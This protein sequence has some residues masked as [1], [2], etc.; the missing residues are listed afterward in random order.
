[1]KD[2]LH[3]KHRYLYLIVLE[4]M[5][6][7]YHTITA[8]AKYCSASALTSTVQDPLT[9]YR[10]SK[11][12]AK[13]H[14]AS[15]TRYT[16]IFHT[17]KQTRK[18]EQA[19]AFCHERKAV[20]NRAIYSLTHLSMSSTLNVLHRLSMNG[21][22]VNSPACEDTPSLSA[23]VSLPLLL[24]LLKWDERAQTI[25]TYRTFCCDTK[26]SGTSFATVR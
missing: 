17:C 8:R 5:Q 2:T 6:S 23:R 24:I 10:K 18:K 16:V 7:S 22:S 25:H 1:M 21:V 15:T 19:H 14:R 20:H 12:L 9:L 4:P 3:A 13:L 11:Q 26:V